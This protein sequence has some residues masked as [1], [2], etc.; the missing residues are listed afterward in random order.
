MVTAWLKDARFDLTFIFGIAL[1]ATAMASVTVYLPLLFLPMLTVH[2][3]AF[4]YE[5]L[6]ATYSKLLVHPEDRAR[7]H[8]LIYYVPPLVLL[9][10]YLVGRFHGLK[11][12]YVL[13]F[14]GQFFHTVRQSWGLAQQYRWQ[15]GGMHWDGKRLSEITLWSVP[16][17]GFLHRANQQPDE[18]LFQEFWL[19]AVPH[20]V[21]QAAGA[22]S[23]ALWLY[24][25]Y[26]RLA[27]WRRGELALGHT[28]YMISHLVI[29]LGGYIIIDEL[30]SGWLMV[31]VWHNVQYIAFVWAYNHRRFAAGLDARARVLSWLS[32]RGYRRA[33][34]Y[35]LASVALALPIY[36][37][38]PQLGL[39]LDGLVK[40]SAV[41][42]AIILGLTLTFHHYIVDGIVW[43]RRNNARSWQDLAGSKM[44]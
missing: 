23:A 22:V 38:L 14:F 26:A 36:Y 42:A 1:L 7:Y 37:L 6:W 44:A 33:A 30:C 20:L 28:L 10:L 43:K 4:G 29:Y 18:F 8:R 31:N 2:S 27:A 12:L 9:G 39:T 16:I 17:W 19:P 15:A 13:Y 41:P 24:W 21:V 11:G 32:Q 40:N 35:I 34:Y 5:H 25:L 3:W